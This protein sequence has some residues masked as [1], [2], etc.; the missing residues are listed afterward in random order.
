MLLR[1]GSCDPLFLLCL[2]PLT[3]LR[4]LAH[5]PLD[6]CYPCVHV[7]AVAIPFILLGIILFALFV[8]ILPGKQTLRFL[9]L[10]PPL[11]G[12][13]CIR[14]LLSGFGLVLFFLGSIRPLL[15][16]MLRKAR[17]PL[18]KILIR[19]LCTVRIE[20]RRLGLLSALDSL[21]MLL[22]FLFVLCV[23]CNEPGNHINQKN[24][25]GQCNQQNDAPGTC[26]HQQ[27]TANGDIFK[28]AQADD[29]I[30]L[31]LGGFCAAGIVQIVNDLCVRAFRIRRD[32]TDPANG[33]VPGTV[34]VKHHIFLGVVML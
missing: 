12:R 7:I 27:R 20:Q 2:D 31:D 23:C 3:L 33:L 32:Q 11:S 5:C 10:C 34:G 19:M 14:R 24:Y 13:L 8:G 29:G 30:F 15:V 4:P 26:H 18:C 17:L 1:L 22:L 9:D 16:E 21:V 28:A 6:S 25:T